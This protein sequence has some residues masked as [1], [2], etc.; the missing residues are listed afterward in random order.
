MTP[1][2]EE[3]LGKVHSELG[4][5]WPN[6][7]AQLCLGRGALQTLKATEAPSFPGSTAK[8]GSNRNGRHQPSF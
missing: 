8:I 7:S 1:M 5:T 6:S 4:V 3:E 2:E